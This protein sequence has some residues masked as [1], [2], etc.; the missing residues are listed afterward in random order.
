MTLK[1]LIIEVIFLAEIRPH[2][3]ADWELPST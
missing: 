2:L 3:P 1:T